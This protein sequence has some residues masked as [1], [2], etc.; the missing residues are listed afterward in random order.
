MMIVVSLSLNIN[1]VR[2]LSNFYNKSP[3]SLDMLDGMLGP[4]LHILEL[5]CFLIARTPENTPKCLIPNLP[6]RALFIRKKLVEFRSKSIRKMDKPSRQAKFYP[7]GG[8][9]MR[10]IRGKK[11]VIL[12]FCLENFPNFASTWPKVL[13]HCRNRY[14]QIL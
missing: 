1:F 3:G 9:G 4:R 6:I 8:S 5:E 12:R 11:A 14:L 2:C 10:K 7:D 13:N